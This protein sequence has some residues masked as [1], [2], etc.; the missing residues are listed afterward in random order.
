MIRISY[1]YCIKLFTRLISII[2]LCLLTTN[3]WAQSN[4]QQAV[5]LEIQG[6]IGPATADYLQRGLATAIKQNAAVIILQMDTPGGLDKAMRRIVHAILASPIP[7]ITYVAPSGA[8]AASA[9]TYILYASHFA[10]MA[11]GTNLGA[12]TPINLGLPGTPND[13]DAKSKTPSTLETKSINDAA[14]YIRSLAQLR[15]R[16]AQWAETAVRQGS[17]LSAHEALKLG[18]ID[19]I[20]NDS[21][22]L[23]AKL[24]GRSVVVQQQKIMLLTTGMTIIHLSPDWRSHF[25]S[26]IT[27][28][29]I[30]YL[31][32][33]LGIWG[34]FLEF[35]H[36]GYILPG[37]TGIIAL[38]LGLYAFQLLPI[39]YAGLGLIL[40][41]IAFMAAEAFL[42][43]FGALGIGGVIAFIIGS[44]M[45]LQ[46]ATPGYEIALPLIIAVSILSAAFFLFLIN[47]A[48]KAHRRPVVSGRE[49]LIG[50]IATIVAI[51]GDKIWTRIHGE[52]WQVR[53]DTPLTVG[54]KVKIIRLDGV[55]LVVESI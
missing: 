37:V 35:T 2:I 43:T 25:L 14:A 12:A 13:V 11:P 21:A 48:V 36:P 30:A 44:V 29:N 5:E 22:D 10:A 49:E 15:N 9:G 55:V 1:R 46:P 51:E 7:V 40:V 3:L 54:Q 47:L 34:L 28:P 50:K 8:R 53:T 39:S 17:S 26:I 27:D 18:V 38:L 33:I 20:A 4:D 42:P 32:M 23:L 19:F 41:G 24:N 6:T 45:L 52:L 31:L 16:N